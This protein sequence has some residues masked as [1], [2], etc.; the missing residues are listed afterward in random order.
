VKTDTSIS[1]LFSHISKI[2]EAKQRRKDKE[3]T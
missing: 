1:I 3:E 2:V